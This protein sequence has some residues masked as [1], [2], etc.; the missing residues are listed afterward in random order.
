MAAEAMVQCLLCPKSCRLLPGERGDC[1]ARVNLDGKLISLVYGKVCSA[2][3]DPIEK[4]PLFHFLPGSSALSV[5]TA[6]CN[7]HCLNCQNWSISQGDPEDVENFDLP[8]EQLVQSALSN[9]CSMIAYT[10]T[11]PVIFFEYA[12]DCCTLA[13]ERGL[14]NVLVSA[15]FINR[16]PLQQLA[17]VTHGANIDLKAFSDDFYR[18]VTTGRLQPV[19]D[20]LVTLKSAGVWLEITNLVIP[21]LN[22]DEA[23]VRQMC[24]W[25]VREL[26]RDTPLHFSRFFPRYKMRDLPRTPAATLQRLRSLAQSEGLDYVYVGNLGNPQF[27]TTYCPSCGAAAIVRR[28]YSIVQ[29]DLHNS[30]CAACGRRLPGVW[31]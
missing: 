1:R 11:D 19:L 30:A 15:G 28:G 2:N 20:A 25:I 10:Y 7:L 12:L 8:P 3:I 29:Y 17:R 14:R 31:E 18:R 26:G 22:D 6:G 9:N 4:K 23:Q 27:E 16:K 5:A 24:R 21:T 13:A